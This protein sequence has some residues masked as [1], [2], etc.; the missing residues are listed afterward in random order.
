MLFAIQQAIEGLVW[1][2]FTN[3]APEL[4][5]AATLAHAFFAYLLWPAWLPLAVRLIEPGAGRRQVLD[6]LLV[7]GVALSA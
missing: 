4:V 7:S 5:R 3:H 6:V 2:G 1:L